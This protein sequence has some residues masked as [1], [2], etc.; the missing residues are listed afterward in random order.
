[1]GF[2]WGCLVGDIGVS[3]IAGTA[4]TGFALTKAS[5]GTYATSTQ[6]VGKVYAANY[7]A[8]TPTTLTTAIGDMQT[9]YADAAGRVNPDFTELGSGVIG[10]RTLVPGLYKWST[11]VLIPTDVT[12]SG[13]STDVWIFQ[14]AGDVSMAS[15]KAVILAGG[16]QAKNIFWQVAGQVT[17]GTTAKFNGIILCKTAVALQTGATMKGRIYAQTAASLQKS[18]VTK[19]N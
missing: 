9:A 10:G 2:R 5:T 13:S 1:M 14:I 18:T 6:V 7:A 12:L 3:P 17:I 15:G 16:A 11:S 8:P 4:I 19:P